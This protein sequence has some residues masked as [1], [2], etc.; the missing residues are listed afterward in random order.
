MTTTDQD[1]R[2]RC[3]PVTLLQ[4]E[5]DRLRHCPRSLRTVNSWGL[6]DRPFHNLDEVLKAAGYLGAKCD[7]SADR[8]LADI[9]RRAATDQLAARIVLQRIFPP[10]LAIGRRRGKMHRTGFDD[11]FSLVLS[12][13]WEIIRTYPIDR[14]PTKIAANIVRDIEYFAFVRRERRRP[15]HERL[16]DSWDLIVDGITTDARGNVLERGDVEAEPLA[17]ELMNALLREARANEISPKSLAM[18]EALRTLTVEQIAERYG[19]SQ[20]T[21]R[22]WRR[23]AVNELRERTLSAA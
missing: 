18:L 20:R 13:G 1:I 16:D 22:E 9:V 21:I 14:R 12:H 7:T 5:W 19:V 10:M 23:D 4:K 17:E 3:N 6:A 15:K 11:A 8:V 2:V